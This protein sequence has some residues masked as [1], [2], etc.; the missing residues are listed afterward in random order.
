M[1]VVFFRAP[2][3][4]IGFI[5]ATFPERRTFTCRAYDSLFSF[6]AASGTAT[7][8]RVASQQKLTPRFGTR[9]SRRIALGTIGRDS[10]SRIGGF[11]PWSFGHA[12]TRSF[13]ANASA[14]LD[15]TFRPFARD[16]QRRLSRTQGSTRSLPPPAQQ[17]D[18]FAEK[19]EGENAG[20]APTRRLAARRLHLDRGHRQPR[21]HA[22]R[23][24]LGCFA[25]GVAWR[26]C[27]AQGTG[28]SFE[29]ILRDFLNDGFALL[30]AAGITTAH[31]IVAQKS[32]SVQRFDQYT[33]LAAVE[34]ALVKDPSLET[35]FGRDYGI[36]P[37]IVVYRPRNDPS[38]LGGRIA[39]DRT[40]ELTPFFT[41][42]RYANPKAM[43]LEAIVSCKLTIRSDRVQNIRPE[44]ANAVRTR[45][46]RMPRIV[47]VTAEPLCGGGR[48]ESIALGTGDVDC[49]YHSGLP[50]LEAAMQGANRTSE[51][52]KLKNLVDGRRLR[53][54][55]DLLFDLIT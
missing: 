9:R 35:V 34:K 29:T 6:M 44:A 20:G 46:G 26:R 54:V 2:A 23:G 47:A 3:S 15:S 5:A 43:I 51:A 45:K 32:G 28:A 27:T 24:T 53:D 10:C 22:D 36:K 39:S 31:D 41:D 25:S 55:S 48:L 14:S 18:S 21:K 49:V 11:P 33:H 13:Q 52:A 19:A 1:S 12:S 4:G 8:A 42:A 17:H 30:V 50:E 40:A 7:T 37:D 38:I 16:L